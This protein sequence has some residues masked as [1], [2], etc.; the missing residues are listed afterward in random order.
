MSMTIEEAMW[1]RVTPLSADEQSQ[2][3]AYLEDCAEYEIQRALYD[4]DYEAVY[5]SS[6][7]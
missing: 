1:L 7:M 2:Q 5:E 4:S 3:L 6:H